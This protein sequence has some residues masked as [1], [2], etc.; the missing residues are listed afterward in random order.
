[1]AVAEAW[2][3]DGTFDVTPPFFMQLYTIHVEIYEVITPVAFCLL[4]NKRKETYIKAF[5]CIK[6]AIVDRGFSLSISAFRSDFEMAAIQA[7]RQ[8]LN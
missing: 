7:M 3:A 4:P 5:T 1:M 6:E 2:F 8:V